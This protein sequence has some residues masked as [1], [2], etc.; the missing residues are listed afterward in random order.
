MKPD[1]AG[2]HNNY[3]LALAQAKKF[4]EA[5]AEL[6]KAAQLEPANAGK[7]YFNLGALLVNNGQSGSKPET[8]SKR[9]STPIPNMPTRSINTA[10]T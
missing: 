5:Q 4:D 7:Y 8:P 2:V 10:S 1:D 3:A 6:G 9:P